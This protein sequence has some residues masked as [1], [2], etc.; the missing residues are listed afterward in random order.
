MAIGL[1]L[2]KLEKILLASGGKFGWETAIV[3]SDSENSAVYGALWKGDIGFF[4]PEIKQ[5]LLQMGPQFYSQLRKFKQNDNKELQTI[6]E[7]VVHKMIVHFTYIFVNEQDKMFADA[8]SFDLNDMPYRE[9]YSNDE[10]G[11]EE[12]WNDYE[13]WTNNRDEWEEEYKKITQNYNEIKAN[14]PVA[15]KRLSLEHLYNQDKGQLQ[16]EILK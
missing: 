1:I 2:P 9:E 10:K 6:L 11:K 13:E 5:T 3:F 14:F 8:V 7:E 15:W 16:Q 4:N 12:Y